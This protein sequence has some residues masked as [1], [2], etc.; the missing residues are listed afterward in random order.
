M[1]PMMVMV[2]HDN[3]NLCLRRIGHC[4]AKKKN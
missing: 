1:M 2:V 3:H 4:E